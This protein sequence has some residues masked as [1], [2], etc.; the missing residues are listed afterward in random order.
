M[1]AAGR[2][3][4]QPELPLD[5]RRQLNQVCDEILM[6]IIQLLGVEIIVCLGRFVE[7][8]VKSVLKDYRL[9]GSVRIEC[10][11]H[12][13]PLNRTAHKGWESIALQQLQQMDVMKYL[14]E[15]SSSMHVA[16]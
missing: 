13:S 2:N 1:N 7:S 11:S 16:S 6:E 10:M 5:V 9:D 15:C 4:T 12:P 14:T 8:R 3:V